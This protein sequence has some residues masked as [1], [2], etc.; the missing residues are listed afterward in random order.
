MS[1][2]ADPKMEKILAGLEP[3]DRKTVEKK[4]KSLEVPSKSGVK[5][6]LTVSKRPPMFNPET[7][8]VDRFFKT[9]EDYVDC[10]KLDDE[11]LKRA[12]RSYLTEDM[13]TRIDQITEPEEDDIT[14]EEYKSL[15]S[16]TL[17]TIR[18]EKGMLSRISL[19]A[20]SQEIGESLT[21][22]ADRIS[23]LSWLAYPKAE[24]R[25]LREERLKDAL[26]NGASRPDVRIWL[27]QH[28]ETLTYQELVSGAVQLDTALTI[29]RMTGAN[30]DAEVSVFATHPQS[31]RSILPKN[32]RAAVQ[33]SWYPDRSPPCN[34]VNENPNYRHYFGDYEYEDERGYNSEQSTGN[35]S[36]N[37]Y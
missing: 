3:E 4:I 21:K 26:S 34:G 14:W 27:N 33:T 9:F 12:F 22:F 31:L 17:S 8:E 25:K 19:K 15:V 11:A 13:N 36:Q 30:K 29:A 35:A 2:L 1:I 7:M 16:Q 18:R 10:L 24:D 20:A 23:Q 6:M 32:S 37:R 5:E 28:A